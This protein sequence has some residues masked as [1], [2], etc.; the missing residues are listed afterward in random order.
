[1]GK[2]VL[3][4][5]GFIRNGITKEYYD[6]YNRYFKDY[7]TYIA[8]PNYAFDDKP[9]DI[10]SEEDIRKIYSGLNIKNIYLWDYDKTVFQQRVPSFVP[11][12]NQWYQQAWRIYSFMYHVMKSVEKIN[13]SDPDIDY[14]IV[15]RNDLDIT[16]VDIELIDR[17][18]KSNSYDMFV[19]DGLQDKHINDK[20]FIIK[21]EYLWLF[22]DIYHNMDKYLD[23]YYN[24]VITP[25]QNNRGVVRIRG[26]SEQKI[27][28]TNIV[29]NHNIPKPISTRPEDL[30]GYHFMVIHKLKLYMGKN[31]GIEI[32]F[33]HVCSKYCGHNGANTA[34]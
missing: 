13:S 24:K 28:N 18:M 17:I 31:K 27:M 19:E 14:I 26:N 34:S 25:P 8:M 29:V 4:L 22:A 12:F 20:Y 11:K 7:E 6:K 10:V 15:I 1:M 2:K 21:K 9:E 32:D 16:N 33:K 3:A 5:F 30:W 23:T